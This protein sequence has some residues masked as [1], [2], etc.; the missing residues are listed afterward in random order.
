MKFT[1]LDLPAE[2]M[3]GI[4]S[5]G[6]TEL[7]PVQEESI[8]LALQGSDVA[9]QA[10]TGTGKTAAFLISLFTKLL[11]SGKETSNNPRALIIAP[12]R[13]DVVERQAAVDGNSLPGLARVA[14]VAEPA[15]GA[16]PDAVLAIDPQRV[17]EIGSQAMRCGE[18]L[19]ASFV[20]RPVAEPSAAGADPQTALG[21]PTDCG[22][23]IRAQSLPGGDAFPGTPVICAVAE[24]A[25]FRTHPDPGS[26][27]PHVGDFVAS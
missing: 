3:R 2:V 1:E 11:K 12:D 20:A 24:P 6:F 21:I 10:Q 5:V 25:V 19:P 27:S 17:H 4:E 26:I 9:A 8:P 22:D 15:A 7:T 18:A 23:R 14:A 16:R 13:S